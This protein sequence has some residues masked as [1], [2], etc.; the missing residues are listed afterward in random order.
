[1]AFQAGDGLD[2]WPHPHI[3]LATLTYLIDGEILH[4]D[5]EGYVQPIRPGQ[6]NVMTAG[7]GIV[8]SMRSSETTRAS[9]GTVFGFQSWVALPTDQDQTPLRVWLR[10]SERT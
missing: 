1:M 4:R 7:R 2:T 6:V 9:G 10:S 3:G 8:H 5:S